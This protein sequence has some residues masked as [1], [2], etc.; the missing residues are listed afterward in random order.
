[1]HVYVLSELKT[2]IASLQCSRVGVTWQQANVESFT[3][4]YLGRVGDENE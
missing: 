1:M 4:H 3:I 2:V